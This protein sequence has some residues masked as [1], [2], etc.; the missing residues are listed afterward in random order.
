MYIVAQ[1]SPLE[2]KK[3]AVCSHSN[4]HDDDIN[5]TEFHHSLNSFD[6]TEHEDF[7]TNGEDEIT[8]IINENCCRM[9]T[10]DDYGGG[11]E[12]SGNFRD[13]NERIEEGVTVMDGGNCCEN[14]SISTL[15][16]RQQY[17]KNMYAMNEQ[18][19]LENIWMSMEYRRNFLLNAKQQNLLNRQQEEKRCQR[20]NFKNKI[21][22]SERMLKKKKRQKKQNNFEIRSSNKHF[23]ENLDVDDDGLIRY[24]DERGNQESNNGSEAEYEQDLFDDETNEFCMDENNESQNLS[25]TTLDEMQN[26]ELIS[27]VNNFSLK[28]SFAWTLGTLLQSTSDL[29][30][31]VSNFSLAL[32]LSIHVPVFSHVLFFIDI[33]IA[34]VLLAGMYALLFG[35]KIYTFII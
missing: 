31:K 7:L 6:G 11:N 23:D 4:E 13:E 33:V 28:N 19:D 27:Y 21:N 12:V 1:I 22:S 17:I 25:F 30:P 20:E 5:D 24:G 8:T 10:G 2:W 9:E 16:Q 35:D 14:Y 29:Y 18:S 34:L 32:M 15:E 26:I 3:A